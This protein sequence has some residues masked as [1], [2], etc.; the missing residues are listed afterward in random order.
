MKKVIV[1]FSVGILLVLVGLSLPGCAKAPV[2]NSAAGQSGATQMN[3][4]SFPIQDTVAFEKHRDWFIAESRKVLTNNGMGDAAGSWKVSVGGS[5]LYEGNLEAGKKIYHEKWLKENPNGKESDF[6]EEWKMMQVPTF[7][8][9]AD[10]KYGFLT[11]TFRGPSTE[12]AESAIIQWDLE[13]GESSLAVA[14]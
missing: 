9:Y 10:S 12:F 11:V 2:A 6:E 4:P 14:N 13:T 8:P 3:P 7:D 1:G 5:N